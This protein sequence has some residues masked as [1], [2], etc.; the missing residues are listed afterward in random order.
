MADFTQLEIDAYSTSMGAILGHLT[1]GSN[2]TLSAL[3]VNLIT[4]GAC[5]IFFGPMVYDRWQ[6]NPGRESGGVCFMVA[7]LGALTIPTILRGLRPW[8]ERNTE[9][10][11]GRLMGRAVSMI[12]PA[13]P[14]GTATA[15]IS[16][17]VV[18]ESPVAKPEEKK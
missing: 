1:S 13:A 9:N 12:A 5:G 7:V 16:T 17:V 2:R 11:I 18:T 14:T 10:I 4:G 6:M 8:T 3:A 15:T